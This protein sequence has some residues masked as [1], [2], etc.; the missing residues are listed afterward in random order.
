V[1]NPYCIILDKKKGREEN[2]FNV[3]IVTTGVEKN[4]NNESNTFRSK[5]INQKKKLIFTNI[6][7]KNSDKSDAIRI[8][9]ES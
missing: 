2:N 1:I 5:E 6:I 7:D 9:E 3:N 4:K 8:S